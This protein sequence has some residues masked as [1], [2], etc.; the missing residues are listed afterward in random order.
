VSNRGIFSLN[1]PPSTRSLGGV[2]VSLALHVVGAGVL[3]LTGIYLR[4]LGTLHVRQ[5]AGQRLTFVNVTVTPDVVFN[6]RLRLKVPELPRKELAPEPLP[7]LHRAEVQ[8]LAPQPL[9]HEV[10]STPKPARP[11]AES[12]A[13]G[14]FQSS[15]AQT[16]APEARR[17]VEATGF[18]AP[19]KQPPSP[20][21][22]LGNAA[23][24]TVQSVAAGDPRSGSDR[25]VGHVIADTGFGQAGPRPR[26]A[27]AAYAIGDAGFGDARNAERSTEPTRAA[28]VQPSG[29]GN[30]EAL[31]PSR[32]PVPMPERVET[33]VE[34]V[35]KPTPE[36]TDEARS[37]KVEGEVLLEV[38]FRASGEVRVLRVVRGLGHGLDESAARAAERIQFKP[39]RSS[40]GPVDFRATVQIVFRLT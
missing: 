25:A 24:G 16:R 17:L 30:V 28:Q 15:A 8:P 3:Y 23:V 33:S 21:L 29:F 40:K 7:R 6:P 32:R 18:D 5:P 13:V 39:A 2:G 35:V 36:Y 38:E 27:P 37:N 19:S 14:A 22:K 11:V 10:P 9:P 34:I 31:P 1:Q 12:V 20:E 4:D 26:Q